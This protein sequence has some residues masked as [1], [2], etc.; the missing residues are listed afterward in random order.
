MSK[1]GGGTT[2]TVQKADPWAG[3]QPYLT[4]QYQEAARLLEQPRQFFPGNLTAPVTATQSEAEALARQTALGTQS[5]LLGQLSP[6]LGFQLGGTQSALA[7][8]FLARSV[9]AATRPLLTGAQGLLQQVRRG[10][11]GQGGLGGTRQGVVEA[12]VIKDYL[13]KAGD[14]SAGMY[15]QAYQ[16]AAKR[17]LAAA[18]MVPGTLGAFQTP[19]SVLSGL[20]ATEQARAQ[21]AIDEARARFEFGQQEP[22]QRLQ[23]YTQIVSGTVLPGTQTTAQTAGS[24]SFGQR[25]IG[26]GLLGLGSY[27]ALSSGAL[28]GTAAQGIAG[29]AGFVPAT[30][31]AAMAGPIAGGL[32][33]LSLFD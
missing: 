11:T 25:A 15:S 32:A 33:L 10:A 20:G 6:A 7:D 22:R 23:D 14:V 12:E 1:G 16:D 26:G 17:Q 28:G 31:L 3:Q 18:Q 19:A 27:G 8:P 9:E 2:Q 21:Q 30:G 29:T 5:E 4:R 24:P 13:T